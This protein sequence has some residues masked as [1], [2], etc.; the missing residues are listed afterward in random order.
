VNIMGVTGLMEC[1]KAKLKA[2]EAVENRSLQRLSLVEVVHPDKFQYFVSALTIIAENRRL[3]HLLLIR[4]QVDRHQV[5]FVVYTR[6]L[7]R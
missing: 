1:E 7:H 4:H 5:K 2:L 3:V 6:K